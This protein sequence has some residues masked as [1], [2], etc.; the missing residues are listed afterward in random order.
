MPGSTPAPVN[1]IRAGY[2][3]GGDPLYLCTGDFVINNVSGSIVGQTRADWNFCDVGYNGVELQST[4]YHYVVPAIST[5]FYENDIWTAGTDDGGGSLGIC[6]APYGTG[7]Q[8]GC[9]FTPRPVSFM[10]RHAIWAVRKRGIHHKWILGSNRIRKHHSMELP[11]DPAAAVRNWSISSY[12]QMVMSYAGVSVEQCS[13]VNKNTNQTT[14]CA[15]GSSASC[16]VAGPTGSMRA[17]L[18]APT[19]F[20]HGPRAVAVVF[21]YLQLHGRNTTFIQ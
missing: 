16:D 19:T 17:L 1:A 15:Y 4:S 9:P 5:T 12:G 14:C 10:V 7:T 13:I 8:V 11:A 18:Q 20:I 2:D 21:E 3:G 6:S